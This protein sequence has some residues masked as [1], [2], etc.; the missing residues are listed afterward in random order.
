MPSAYENMLGAHADLST[1]ACVNAS[2]IAQAHACTNAS[3][4]ARIDASAGDSTNDGF[5][6]LLPPPVLAAAM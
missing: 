3:A 6:L 2:T 1:S 4:C 5:K